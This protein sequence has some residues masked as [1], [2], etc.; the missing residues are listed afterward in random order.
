VGIGASA[1]GV[2]ALET[3]FRAVPAENGMAFVVVTHLPPDRDSL[4]AEILGRATQMPV[5]N[6]QDEQPV[7]AQHVYVLPSSAVLTIREG[8]LRLRHIGTERERAPIDVFFTSLAEDQGEHA[9]GVVLS[10]GGS[11]GTLGLKA[12]KENGGLTIAQGA[13]VTRPRFADMPSNAVA[14]GF[15]DLVLPVEDIAGRIIAYV[16]NWAALDAERSDEALGKIYNLLCTR[17]GHDFSE[18]KDRTFQRRVQRRMQVAQTAKLEDYADR[19]QQD[20]DEVRA[21]F[22]DLLIGVTDFFRDAEAFRA[23]E[24]QVVPKLFKGKGAS[25]EVRVWVAGC[26][27]GEE[28]YSIAILLRE[29]MDFV[30]APPKVQVFARATG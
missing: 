18:Y 28:A 27:T 5:V 30:E 17:T 4:L 14:A 21:L 24:T 19:L 11:D 1:G 12:V 29:Q 13:N 20:T 6:A 16:N 26:A 22:R 25:D 8:R 7:Q 2:E 15:V 9:I 3:F 23:L 10:G